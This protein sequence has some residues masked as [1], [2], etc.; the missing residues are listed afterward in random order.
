MEHAIID[1]PSFVSPSFEL[2]DSCTYPDMSQPLFKSTAVRRLSQQNG[3]LFSTSQ[4]ALRLSASSSA[5]Q[6][7]ARRL[8]AASANGASVYR[9]FMRGCLYRSPVRQSVAS[10]S[11]SPTRL[12]TK[13][14]QNPRTGDDGEA[15][16]ISISPRAV[17]VRVQWLSFGYLA[18]GFCVSTLHDRRYALW[19]VA[20]RQLVLRPWKRTSGC[21]R[22]WILHEI[23]WIQLPSTA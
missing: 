4:S 23:G 15:L 10:F 2:S 5:G 22:G 1:N 21:C 9:P 14:T 13:V 20:S 18:F 8:T 17:T 19:H 6:I 3:R 7:A 11:S 16:M 12:A